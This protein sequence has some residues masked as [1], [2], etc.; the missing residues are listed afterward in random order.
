MMYD[1]EWNVFN[2]VHA[3]LKNSDGLRL[4]PPVEPW[5]VMLRLEARVGGPWITIASWAKS[6]EAPC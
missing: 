1:R 5:G 3:A 4:M 6:P 2:A